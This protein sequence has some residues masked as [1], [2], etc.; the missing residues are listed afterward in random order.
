MKLDENSH[1]T[2]PLTWITDRIQ[3]HTTESAA[4]LVALALLLFGRRMFWLFVGGIGFVA[5][6]I[7]TGEYFKASEEWM[8][9]AVAVCLGL[10]GAVLS[11]FL[12][13]IAV[14]LAGLLAGGYVVYMAALELGYSQYAW[15]GGVIGAALGFFL[16]AVLFDWSLIV[17]SALT[18]S[19]LICQ[20]VP[21]ESMIR[22]ILF[23]ALFAAGVAVQSRHLTK[24]RRSRQQKQD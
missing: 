10:I 19:M 17:L 5:G 8:V 15:I 22:V 16:V 14:R 23:V 7:L 21:Y 4:M 18:G 1:E 24:W 3:A 13:K 12:H 2:N 9:L 20:A 11:I 6:T